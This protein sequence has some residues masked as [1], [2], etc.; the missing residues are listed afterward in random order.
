MNVASSMTDTF[1]EQLRA[2]SVRYRIMGTEMAGW[3]A[4][5]V[6]DGTVQLAGRLARG[7]FPALYDEMQRSG[8]VRIP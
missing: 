5:G 6:E 2:E 1:N 7:L 3:L 4:D 8:V